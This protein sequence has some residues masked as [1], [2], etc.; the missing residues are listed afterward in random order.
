LLGFLCAIGAGYGAG[1]LGL[2]LFGAP[3][4]EENVVVRVDPQSVA[5]T[6]AGGEQPPWPDAFGVFV[7]EPP[8]PPEP[9]PEAVVV[10]LNYLLKGLFA[11]GS[12]AWAIVSD[13]S[14][15]YLLRAG[16][17]L[18]GGALVKSIDKAGVWLETPQGPQLIAF[19]DR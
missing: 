10:N 13:P 17:E 8:A 3:V 9:E 4:P 12:T 14:G 6:Q 7:P 1:H 16:D 19:D 11:N 18:P 2:T 15:E 5:A